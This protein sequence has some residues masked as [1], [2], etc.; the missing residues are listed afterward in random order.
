MIP[1]FAAAG[2][3]YRHRAEDATVSRPW[4]E[5]GT[6]DLTD[7]IVLAGV[8][9]HVLA[10]R[11]PA[12]RAGEGYR[13]TI[14]GRCNAD[15]RVSKAAPSWHGC[16]FRPT[17]PSAPRRWNG[18]VREND[19]SCAPGNAELEVRGSDRNS[20]PSG[21]RARWWHIGLVRVIGLPGEDRCRLWRERSLHV[22]RWLARGVRRG[23]GTGRRRGRCG[24]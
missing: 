3:E 8:R 1:R 12:R 22:R 18:M 14:M 21:S 23:P 2:T 20:A 4:A 17:D 15:G 10:R 13:V 6:A 16:P 19:G 11:G 7:V 24:R 5:C 9:R